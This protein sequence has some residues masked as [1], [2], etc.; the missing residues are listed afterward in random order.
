MCLALVF[1]IQKL[2]HYV[3]AHTM[4]VI[5]KANPIKYIL[6]RPV[7]NGR[8][9]KWAV[10]LEQYDL[11]YMPQNVVKG[12]AVANFLT[13]HPVLDKWELSDNLP[14]VEVF[15]VD[16]LPPWELYFDGAARPD[17]SGA[18]VILVFPE[19][20]ILPYS[21][22]LTKLC[23]NNVAEYQAL[24]L[25]LQMVIEMGIKDLD[26]YNDLQFVINQ[27]LKEFRVKKDDLIP[28]HKHAL[29][30]LDR[31]EN[32]KLERVPRSANMI[33]DALA[34]LTATLAL[35]AKENIKVPVCGHW[36]VTSL[37]DG[38]EEEVKVVF[39]C[40]VDKEDSSHLLTT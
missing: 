26:V 31:L 38:G 5:S 10:I 32:V 11:L 39:A 18:G 17:G 8:L 4:H 3:Q 9:V 20:R 12:Q 29:R 37:D 14:G 23:S 33:A 28:Y 13:D 7:L 22:A 25:G 2:R 36:V 40:V 30:L 19:K 1:G 16:A 27:L 15:L 34:K 35:G 6:T 24:R 21:F